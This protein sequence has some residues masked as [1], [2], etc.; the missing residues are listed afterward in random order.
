MVQFLDDHLRARFLLQILSF[1]NSVS[2]SDFAD[3]ANADASIIL[4]STSCRHSRD[5]ETTTMRDPVRCVGDN[6]MDKG[7]LR[8]FAAGEGIVDG[9]MDAG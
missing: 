9:V 2:S 3:D 1:A 7:K 4:S 6:P 5:F 8:G